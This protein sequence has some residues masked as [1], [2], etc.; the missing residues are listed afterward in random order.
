M[1]EKILSLSPFVALLLTAAPE[2]N[3]MVTEGMLL[4]YLG[5]C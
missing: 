5:L 2:P 4:S 3:E 1:A